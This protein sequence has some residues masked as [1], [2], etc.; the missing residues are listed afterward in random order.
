[1]EIIFQE[2][3]SVSFHPVVM[4]TTFVVIIRVSFKLKEFFYHFHSFKNEFAGTVPANK[5]ELAGTIPTNKNKF[6]GAVPANKNQFAGTH[7]PV[8]VIFISNK[9]GQG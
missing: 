9:E 7:Q 1:M 4:S 5:N 2:I 8:R 6:A 3:L